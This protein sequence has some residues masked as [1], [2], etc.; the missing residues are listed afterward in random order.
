MRGQL[1]VEVKHLVVSLEEHQRP[2]CKR[3]S[4]TE[5]QH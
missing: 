1:E 5:K 3:W 2:I 4:M